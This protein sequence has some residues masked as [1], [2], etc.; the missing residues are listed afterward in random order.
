MTV[1]VKLCPLSPGPS[2]IPEAAPVP[3]PNVMVCCPEFSR[4]GAGAVIVPSVG[5]WL[6]GVT[7]TVKVCEKVLTLAPPVAPLS[8]T[9]TVIFAVPLA[10]GCRL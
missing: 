3:G 4:I 5:A 10:L 6:T 7:V 2:V 1:T 9:V 8:V